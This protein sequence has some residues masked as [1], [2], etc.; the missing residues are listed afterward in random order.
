MRLFH[1]QKAPGAAP[2][3]EP[4]QRREWGFPGR[5]PACN[6]PGYLDRIDMIDL[7][8]YQHCPACGERWEEYEADF[9]R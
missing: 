9:E 2:A 4:R 8:M 7:V 6:D 5:C 1:R 3:A